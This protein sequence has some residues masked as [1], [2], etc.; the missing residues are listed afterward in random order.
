MDPNEPRGKT[1]ASKIKIANI[2]VFLNRIFILYEGLK[3]APLK[4]IQNLLHFKDMAVNSTL[5]G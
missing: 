1:S 4:R 5:A 2:E 3:N